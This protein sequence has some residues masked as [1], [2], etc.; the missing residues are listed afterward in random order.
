LLDENKIKLQTGKQNMSGEE[1]KI[2][3]LNFWRLYGFAFKTKFQKLNN[4]TVLTN[5]Y[6]QFDREFDRLGLLPETVDRLNQQQKQYIQD[7]VMEKQILYKKLRG[8]EQNQDIVHRLGNDG[9]EEIQIFQRKELIVTAPINDSLSQVIVAIESLL[10]QKRLKT[11]LNTIFVDF[12]EDEYNPKFQQKNELIDKNL[13]IPL[14]YFL[15][16]IMLRIIFDKE[17]NESEK[18]L[19]LKD[20]LQKALQEYYEQQKLIRLLSE[21]KPIEMGDYNYNFLYKNPKFCEENYLFNAN[22][23]YQSKFDEI[24]QDALIQSVKDYRT[25]LIDKLK[26][27]GLNVFNNDETINYFALF[28]LCQNKI[29]NAESIIPIHSAI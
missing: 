17:L 26:Y 16:P 20:I 13:N 7:S 21:K 1:I 3:V 23:S 6:S 15:F 22:V 10:N 2:P 14:V 8:A 24:D 29:K 4:G 9:E 27:Y 5:Y 25:V 12:F 11:I 28:E 18:M 19:K